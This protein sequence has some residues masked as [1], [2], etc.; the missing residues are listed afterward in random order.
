MKLA[1]NLGQVRQSIL[2]LELQPLELEQGSD[3]TESGAVVHEELLGQR[4]K[5]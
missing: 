4:P 3:D 1:L 2:G 5:L